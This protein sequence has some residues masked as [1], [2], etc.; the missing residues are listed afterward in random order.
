MG[1]HTKIE[2]HVRIELLRARAALEREAFAEQVCGVAS[3]LT[4]SSLLQRVLP[5]SLR[6]VSG[7]SGLL[8]GGLRLLRQYPFLLSGVSTLLGRGALLRRRGLL[9]SALGVVLLWQLF[10][11]S[12]R[13]TNKPN[14]VFD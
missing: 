1:R 6:S 9:Q 10:R 3:Q 2:R 5:R 4:P 7:Q 13:D 8:L 11:R 12:S 14:D